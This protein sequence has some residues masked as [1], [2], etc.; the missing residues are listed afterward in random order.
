MDLEAL[1]LLRT[2]AEEARIETLAILDVNAEPPGWE[3]N[4]PMVRNLTRVL[5]ELDAEIQRKEMGNEQER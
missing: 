1:R 2:V 5:S 4:Q 3:E